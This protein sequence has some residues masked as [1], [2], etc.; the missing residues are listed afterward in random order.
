MTPTSHF[1]AEENHSGKNSEGHTIPGRLPFY[2]EPNVKEKMSK[3]Q[4]A[5]PQE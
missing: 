4:H 2:L 3:F 5:E 1:M